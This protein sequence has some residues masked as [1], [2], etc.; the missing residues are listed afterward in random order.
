M[1]NYDKNIQAL[2]KFRPDLALKMRQG[3]G[4]PGSLELLTAKSG[5]PTV[6]RNG[7]LL[8]SSYDPQR[9]AAAVIDA[10]GGKAKNNIFALGFALGYHIDAFLQRGYDFNRIFIIEPDIELFRCALRTRNLVPLFEN[11][12]ILFLIGFDPLEVFDHLTYKALLVMS[13]KI[14]VM[15]YQPAI[16]VNRKYFEDIRKKIVDAVR[17]SAANI[18][19][20][21]Y[22]NRIFI[23]NVAANLV[24]AVMSPGINTL[25]N[26]FP[27]AAAVIVSAGPSLDKNIGLLKKAKGKCLI[28]ATDTSFKILLKNGIKPDLVFTEDFKDASRLHFNN[29]E[30]NDVPLVFD[31]QSSP[32]SLQAYRSARFVAASTRPFPYLI[33]SLGEDKGSVA[34][35]MSVAHFAFSAATAFGCDPIIFIGQD[36]SFT[37]GFSHARGTSS[38]EKITPAHGKISKLV[39]V[40]SLLTGEEVLTNNQMYIYLRHFE[41]IISKSN[42]MCINATEGGAGIKGAGAMKLTDAIRKYC[43]KDIQ[44]AEIIREAR[45]GAPRPDVCMVIRKVEDLIRSMEGV[46]DASSQIMEILKQAFKLSQE[47]KP[48]IRAISRHLS[49]LKAPADK[50]M[51][52]EAILMIIHADL[53]EHMMQQRREGRFDPSCLEDVEVQDMEAHFKDDFGFQKAVYKGVTFVIECLVK[54]LKELRK[55]A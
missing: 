44:I 1:N 26:K 6:R 9:E 20:L 34:M 31:M 11:E 38:R 46:K 25:F 18:D 33:N 36:L 47:Q 43:T 40:K 30:I 35:G 39:R 14:S 54:S 53:L 24:E 27:D 8:H 22:A 5:Q 23:E 51:S 19:T 32:A 10:W 12:R 3:A 2:D 21:N 50:V 13:S 7:L 16:A 28:L 41:K 4:D 52:A 29:I 17:T 55:V 48:D 49:R 37:D 15:E 45:A 42:R